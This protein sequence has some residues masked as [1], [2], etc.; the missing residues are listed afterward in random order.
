MR[1]LITGGTGLVGTPISERFVSLGWDVRVIG[2]EAEFALP[3]VEYAQCDIRDVDSLAEQVA[4]CDAMWCIW[5]PYPVRARTPTRPFSTS[6]WPVLTRSLRPRSARVLSA[7]PKP[8]PSMPSA[9]TG[10][11]TIASMT[12]FPL[13]RICR[14]T[15]PTP[16]RCQSNWSRISLLTFGAAPASAAFHFACR[17]SGTMLLSPAGVCVIT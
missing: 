9:A 10:A 1:I 5:P 13:T 16:T 2:A 3:G 12:T 14:C 8:A 4:G 6:T 7:S 11:T 15:P 17:P